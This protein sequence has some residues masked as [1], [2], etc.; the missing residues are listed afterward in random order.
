MAEVK[1]YFLRLNLSTAGT[2]T[3]IYSIN[4]QYAH[5]SIAALEADGEETSWVQ[6]FGIQA[7]MWEMATR[8]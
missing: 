3:R 7:S 4:F 2:L 5:F 8:T 6:F 1:G